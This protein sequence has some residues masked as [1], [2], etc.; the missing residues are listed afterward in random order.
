MNDIFKVSKEFKVTL[1]AYDTNLLYSHKDLKL[2]E[3]T[4]NDELF[5]LYG[6]LTVNKL[7]LNAI[8]SLTNLS[9]QYQKLLSHNISD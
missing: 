5:K 3:T 2:L 1:F 6:W 9:A 7:T 4:V 8:K